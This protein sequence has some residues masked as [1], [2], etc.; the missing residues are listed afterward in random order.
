M[1]RSVTIL[2]LVGIRDRFCLLFL[3]EEAK[4]LKG[5]LRLTHAAPL[6]QHYRQDHKINQNRLISL[7]VNYL[8][9]VEVK[10]SME[11][12]CLQSRSGCNPDQIN[13]N[14]QPHHENREQVFSLCFEGR[15]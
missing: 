7:D 10:S 5:V 2:V 15:G 11:Q 8:K 12:S 3:A 13:V 14:L 4:I 9:N 1:S 6:L